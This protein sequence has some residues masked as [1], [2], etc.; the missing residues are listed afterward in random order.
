M[1]NNQSLQA[2]KNQTQYQSSSVANINIEPHIVNNMNQY[3]FKQNPQ[4]NTNLYSMSGNQFQQD[5]AENFSSVSYKN[6][7][8]Q[9][10]QGKHYDSIS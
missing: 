6:Q 3:G 9:N 4:A 10:K 8:V 5:S 1:N 2:K 7:N